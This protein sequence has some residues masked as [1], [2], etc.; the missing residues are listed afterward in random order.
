MIEKDI[1]HEEIRVY[2][3]G[4]IEYTINN[5]VLLQYREGVSTHRITDSEGWVHC[6]PV[7]GQYGCAVKWKNKEGK[8]AKAHF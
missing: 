8:P 7:P 2:I 6:I 4:G 5:P 3:F 1:S